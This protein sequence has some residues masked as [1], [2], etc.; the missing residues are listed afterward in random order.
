MLRLCGPNTSTGEGGRPWVA[1]RDLAT[2][3]A[4]GAHL[5]PARC[6]PRRW[7][8]RSSGRADDG[9]TAADGSSGSVPATTSASS[10]RVMPDAAR[11][12]DG[13]HRR[14]HTAWRARTPRPSRQP[15]RARRTRSPRPAHGRPDRRCGPCPALPRPRTFD[16]RDRQH[17]HEHAQRWCTAHE[18][19]DRCRR[20]SPRRVGV[21][22][23]SELVSG[24]RRKHRRRL[25]SSERVGRRAARFGVGRVCVIADWGP[26]P[27]DVEVLAGH[28]FDHV[29]ATRL[30][31]DPTCAAALKATA[32]EIHTRDCRG[33][34]RRRS[35]TRDTPPIAGPPSD[36]AVSGAACA[37]EGVVRLVGRF[38][39]R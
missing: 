21:W 26:I 19:F 24:S 6:V 22:F 7:R 1:G 2:C 16:R 34:G 9:S 4:A 17:G 3:N 32:G 20:T 8:R 5:V 27:A 35:T 28:G 39:W 36:G 23:A 10:A 15:P 13:G 29:L 11:P 38:R 37:I 31:R 30:H 33:R 25:D 12:A 18:V 14:P